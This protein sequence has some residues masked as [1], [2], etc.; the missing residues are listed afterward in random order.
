MNPGEFGAYALI[1]VAAMTVLSVVSAVGRRIAG[2]YGRRA[3]LQAGVLGMSG[4]VSQSEHDD[5]KDE[6]ARLR[7]ELDAM[8][9]RLAGLDEIQNRLDFTERMIGQLKNKPALPGP[10]A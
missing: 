7:S 6:V 8:H 5:L 4:G 1:V 9:E 10:S 3:R 2:P